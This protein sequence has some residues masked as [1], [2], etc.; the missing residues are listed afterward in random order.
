MLCEQLDGSGFPLAGHKKRMR[1]QRGNVVKGEHLRGEASCGLHGGRREGDDSRHPEM[2][3]RSDGDGSA[4]RMSC[5]D[6]AFGK[7][8]FAFGEVAGKRESAGVVAIWGE[9]AGGAA[10]TGKIGNKDPDVLIG[11]LLSIERHDAFIGGE[12]VKKND[13]ADGSARARFVDVEGHLTAASGREDGVHLVGFT[14]GQ[15]VAKRAK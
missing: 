1:W 13:R 2:R 8:G 4:E 11:E 7:D 14:M 5:E 9:R 15:V 3:G 6:G 10:M 12:T